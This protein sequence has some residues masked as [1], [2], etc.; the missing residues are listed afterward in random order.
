MFKALLFFGLI[1]LVGLNANLAKVS[2]IEQIDNGNRRD[3]RDVGEPC[4]GPSF[5]G[6]NG[7][8]CDP[9]PP[10]RPAPHGLDGPMGP[11]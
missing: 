4:K 9:G 10:G 8:T 3:I 5:C 11:H 1:F 2:N 6:P 7:C